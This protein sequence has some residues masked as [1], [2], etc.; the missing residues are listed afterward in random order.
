M[1]L[2]IIITLVILAIFGVVKIAQAGGF[3]IEPRCW[4]ECLKK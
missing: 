1:T 4:D 3:K 2:V